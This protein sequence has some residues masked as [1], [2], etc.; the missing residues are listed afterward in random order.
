MPIALLSEKI[1]LF[2]DKTLIKRHIGMVDKYA[3]KT[4]S[5]NNSWLK[6]E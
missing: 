6:T 2:L 5:I 3:D 4:G 1:I